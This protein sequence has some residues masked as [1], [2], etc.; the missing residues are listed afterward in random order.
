MV[1]VGNVFNRTAMVVDRS[2]FQLNL[3]SGD[4]VGPIKNGCITHGFASRGSSGRRH[5]TG[6]P[7][8]EE[9]EKA[10]WEG[11]KHQDADHVIVVLVGVPIWFKFAVIIVFTHGDVVL[12][13]IGVISLIWLEGE[14]HSKER[15]KSKDPAHE[16]TED[17]G[18]EPPTAAGHK[19]E[20]E[21]LCNHSDSIE[22]PDESPARTIFIAVLV[23]YAV[24]VETAA[25]LEILANFFKV[26]IARIVRGK[27]AAIVGIFESAALIER[28]IHWL[29]FVLETPSS[30][31]GHSIRYIFVLSYDTGVVWIV[32]ACSN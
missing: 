17:T 2:V 6:H 21:W 25:I 20:V 23:Y 3:V 28:S 11:A 32:R 24:V 19:H 31:C 4:E 5:V 30:S 27:S 16:S 18:P 1:E 15:S 26:F 7:A 9:L 12:A 29:E 10:T 8:A 22:E 14:V 13:E